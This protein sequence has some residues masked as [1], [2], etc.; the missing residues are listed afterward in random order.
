MRGRVVWAV[1]FRGAFEHLDVGMTC[2]ST[3]GNGGLLLDRLAS[4]KIPLG[5]RKQLALQVGGETHPAVLQ[6]GEIVFEGAVGSS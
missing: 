3:D 5:S 2:V 6:P 1:G 4:S